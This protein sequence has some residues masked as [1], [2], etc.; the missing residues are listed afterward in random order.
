MLQ[1]AGVS[2]P[3]RTFDVENQ[4]PFS[5]IVAV[6]VQGVCGSTA[7]GDIGKKPFQTCPY[8]DMIQFLA[9]LKVF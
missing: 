2:V 9:F 1:D 8:L 6:K 7:P 5:F 3:Q 4:G